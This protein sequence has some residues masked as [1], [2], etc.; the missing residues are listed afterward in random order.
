MLVVEDDADVRSALVEE[1]T[2]R[3]YS[4]RA[5]GEAWAALREVADACPRVVVLDLGLPDMDGREL[6]K[7]I[8]A[9]SDAA[10]VVITA[11]DAEEEIVA[12]LRGGADDYM[13]KPFRAG[14]LDARIGAV[15]RRM[16]GRPTAVIEVGGLRLDLRRHE[17]WLDGA[18]LDL[19]PRE[20]ELLAYLASRPGE[21]ISRA[22]LRR[23]VWRQPYGG[24]Q[25]VDVHLSWLRRKLGETAAAPRFLST[26][27][28]VGVRFDVPI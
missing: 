27:R 13:V 7:L 8:R 6:L 4:V 3:G 25:T 19:T 14:E 2:D 1:L 28:G 17:A 18:V 10:I 12:I 21:V 15:L 20:F 26:V 16:A 9:V 23:E 22:E 5:T 24:D 11:R